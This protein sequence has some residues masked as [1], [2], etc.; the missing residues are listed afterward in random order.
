MMDRRAPRRHHA[1]EFD[2]PNPIVNRH[3]GRDVRAGTSN[4]ATDPPSASA[5]LRPRVLERPPSPS[6]DLPPHWSMKPSDNDS[7]PRGCRGHPCVI[8]GWDGCPNP[9]VPI[10]R[11]ASPD[12]EGGGGKTT[13]RRNE[14]DLNRDMAPSMTT[15]PPD[16]EEV[17][18]TKGLTSRNPSVKIH[19]PTRLT[20]SLPRCASSTDNSIIRRLAHLASPSG[21]GHT[22]IESGIEEEWK[23]MVRFDADG[24]TRSVGGR[25]KMESSRSSTGNVTSDREEGARKAVVVPISRSFIH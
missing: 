10:V 16:G 2:E 5:S 1:I 21:K 22:W 19:H 4:T 13:T 6:P 3:F 14:R 15:D 8:H 9:V 17:D 20:N 7:S 18:R 23:G 11:S 12:H 25:S 24:V